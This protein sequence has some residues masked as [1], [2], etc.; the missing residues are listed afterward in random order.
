MKIGDLVCKTKGY[1]FPGYV[2]ADFETVKGERRIVV[3]MAIYVDGIAKAIGLL[4]IFNPEQLEV[5]YAS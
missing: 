4:H 2:V 1:P 5:V 3:E